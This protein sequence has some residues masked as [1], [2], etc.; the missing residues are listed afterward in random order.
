MLQLTQSPEP[1]CL[2]RQGLLFRSATDYVL[3]LRG[4]PIGKECLSSS[5]R[6]LLYSLQLGRLFSPCVSFAYLHVNHDEKKAD[7]DYTPSSS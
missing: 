4:Q 6:I 5:T 1:G 3:P 2:L 7:L